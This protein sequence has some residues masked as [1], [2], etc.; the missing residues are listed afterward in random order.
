MAD[1]INRIL[2]GCSREIRDL[3]LAAHHQGYVVEP[4]HNHHLRVSPPPDCPEKSGSVHVAGTPSDYRGLRN[5]RSR[6][7]RIGVIIPH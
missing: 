6:L 4:T 7:R 3:L 1:D 5:L 2:R